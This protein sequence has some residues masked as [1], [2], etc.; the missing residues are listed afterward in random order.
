MSGTTATPG[1]VA[2][3]YAA[4]S[5]RYPEFLPAVTQPL[6]QMF[7]NEA[8]LYIDNTATS[9]F[10]DATHGGQR[11]TLLN[12]ATAHIA[13]LNQPGA[14]PLVGRIA[15]ANQGSVSVSVDYKAA[16]TEQWWAQTR[17]GAALWA[18]TASYRTMQYLPGPSR[19]GRPGA[20]PFPWS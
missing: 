15:S 10:A 17:Y 7:F 5:T 9:A 13:A 6:A 20:W 12:M 11:E 14:S 3:D 1:V 18:A 19:T 2:F 8:C 4:W 16:G